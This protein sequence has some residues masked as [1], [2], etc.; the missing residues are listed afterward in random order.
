M[1]RALKWCRAVMRAAFY[2][3]IGIIVE[4]LDLGEYQND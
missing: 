3:L 4:G 1:K 2:T